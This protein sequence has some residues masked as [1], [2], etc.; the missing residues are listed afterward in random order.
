MTHKTIPLTKGFVTIVDEGDYDL[1]AKWKWHYHNGYAARVQ[2][3]GGGKK[4]EKK[5]KVYMHRFIMN[6]EY[7]IQVDH[8]N[9]DELDNRR[10]N[11]RLC[12]QSQNNWNQK[13]RKNGSS[14]YKGVHWA[15]RD[16]RW[17]TQIRTNGEYQC[18][19]YF[20]DEIEAAKAYN[21]A[22]IK[23]HGEFARLNI[24]D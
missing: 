22:A 4:N 18:L 23:L 8:I 3:L 24:I 15:K 20:I 10:C 6:A 2:Y 1:L 7:G 12:S 9:H 21:E 14:K 11:L 13:P 16:K 19:G 17:I 5:K